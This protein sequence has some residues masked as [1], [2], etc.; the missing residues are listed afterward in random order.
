MN[1]VILILSLV[2]IYGGVI[3]TYRL[4]GKAGIFAFIALVTIL[5]NIEVLILVEAFG[6]EQTLGNLLFA[7]TFLATDILSEN[8]GKKEADRAVNIGIFTAAMMVIITQSWLFYIPSESDWVSP[9][10]S[11]VF[12]STPRLI[13]ASMLGY[14]VS[15]KFDV[16]IYHLIWKI[17]ENKTGDKTAFLWL[18]NNGATLMAQLINTVLFN[19]A[20]FGGVYETKTLV[21][22]IVS[23]YLIYIITALLDTP[24]VY[25]AR[26]L[27]CKGAIPQ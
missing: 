11:A 3:L 2:I 7:S 6:M 13:L 27:K 14:T 8:E 21:S 10:I 5:A 26:K 16:W 12:S 22:I 24:I 4:F 15:Q 9:S 25:I 1:E 18:R 19:V 20:A 17:T 23:G